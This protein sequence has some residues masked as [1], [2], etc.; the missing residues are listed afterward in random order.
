MINGLDNHSDQPFYIKKCFLICNG[1]IY[2]F[3][4]LKKEFSDY[5]TRVIVKLLFIFIKNMEL[6]EH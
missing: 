1:E 6:R 5:Q 3:A 2:N 4:E